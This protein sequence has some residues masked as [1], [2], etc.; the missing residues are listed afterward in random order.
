MKTT[1]EEPLSIIFAK[2]GRM[3]MINNESLSVQTNCPNVSVVLT[4]NQ[5]G[6]LVFSN[7]HVT[8]PQQIS[9]Y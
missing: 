8:L 2:V 5:H 4:L 7:G 9:M 3:I 1:C 6:L